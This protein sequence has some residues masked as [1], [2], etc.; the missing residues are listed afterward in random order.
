MMREIKFRAWDKKEK[1][2]YKPVYQAYKGKLFYLTLNIYNGVLLLMGMSGA[3]ASKDIDDRFELMQYTGLKDKNG[4]EIYKGDILK[5]NNRNYQVDWVD[6]CGM[7]H[8]WT[9]GY[10]IQGGLFSYSEVIGNIHE[11]LELLEVKK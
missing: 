3:F 8:A 6:D 4:K 5:Y 10:C 2:M 11:N 1:K 7:F 9:I